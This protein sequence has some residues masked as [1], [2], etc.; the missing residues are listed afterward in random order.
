MRFFVVRGVKV[1]SF[2][3]RVQAHGPHEALQMHA[4]PG[5]AALQAFETDATWLLR[6]DV[7]PAAEALG[8]LVVMTREEAAKLA[9]LASSGEQLGAELFSVK[10]ALE[11][12]RAE[13]E[14][15]RVSSAQS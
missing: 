2:E 8:G 7:S 15:L 6:S 3:E 4:V 13:V 11:T 9:E 10:N 5:L 14:E 1:V 12:L